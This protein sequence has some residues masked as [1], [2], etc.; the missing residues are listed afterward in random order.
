MAA[1]SSEGERYYFYGSCPLKDQCTQSSFKKA[2]CWGWSIPAARES[3]KNHLMN[4]GCHLLS[5]DKAYEAI[6]DFDDLQSEVVKE[7]SEKRR[8]TLEEEE[9]PKV[10]SGSS[11]TPKPPPKETQVQAP[12]GDDVVLTRSQAQKI[13]KSVLKAR[14]AC[15]ALERL[16]GDGRQ[17]FADEAQELAEQREILKT[18][19]ERRGHE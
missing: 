1:S 19:L 7:A 13:L 18:I 6:D 11:M 5:E 4:S 9:Q 15:R 12:R 3:L 10:A 16:C 14:E 8:R 2:K 17:A